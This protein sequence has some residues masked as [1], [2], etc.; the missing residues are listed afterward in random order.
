MWRIITVSIL[1][2]VITAIFTYCSPRTQRYADHY[3]DRGSIVSLSKNETCLIRHRKAAKDL[4]LRFDRVITDS[5]CPK[6][7]VCVWEGFA[8]VDLQLITLQ[9]DSIPLNLFTGNSNHHIYP[10][11]YDTLGV[12]IRV[13]QLEPRPGMD[14]HIDDRDYRLRLRIDKAK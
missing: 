9:N 10:D 7:I 4:I 14:D 8:S 3:T 6:G 2:G 1:L 5:R 13:E 12:R 11:H